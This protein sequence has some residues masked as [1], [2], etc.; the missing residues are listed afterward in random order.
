MS[1]SG[2]YIFKKYK[3]I[4]NILYGIT[5]IFPKRIR[6]KLFE[7]H[8]NTPGK[9]GVLI[10]YIYIKSLAKKCGDNVAIMQNV[11]FFNVDKLKTTFFHFF[12]KNFFLHYI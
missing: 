7:L 10:R 5:K 9:I 2:R 3:F 1:K 8:R 6:I 12:A 4:I 11:Y